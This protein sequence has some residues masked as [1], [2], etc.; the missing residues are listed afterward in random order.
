MQSF[1]FV[2][3]NGWHAFNYHQI[4]QKL[5]AVLRNQFVPKYYIGNGTTM[6]IS[7]EMA[8]KS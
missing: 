7:L 6:Y 5:Y 1:E 3:L 8:C 2:I 4:N